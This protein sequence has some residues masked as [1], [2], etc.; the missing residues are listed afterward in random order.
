[1][2]WW[3]M[4][5]WI[6]ALSF[7]QTILLEGGAWVRWNC[8][9]PFPFFSRDWRYPY[10][11]RKPRSRQQR[12]WPLL[13]LHSPYQT[14]KFSAE[15][16]VGEKEGTL[17]IQRCLVDMSDSPCVSHAC[18]S[19]TETWLCAPH[20]LLSILQQFGEQCYP[21]AQLYSWDSGSINAV[22]KSIWLRN[23]AL[24]DFNL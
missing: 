10:T 3:E 23:R 1:M 24:H 11:T 7:G 6:C 20:D 4:K 19:S 2:A 18:G 16:N 12:I 22:Y 15:W 14:S 9:F 5:Q 17:V 8:N 13:L 21:Y